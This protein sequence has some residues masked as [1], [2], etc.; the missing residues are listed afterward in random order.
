MARSGKETPPKDGV[1]GAKDSSARSGARRAFGDRPPSGNPGT[2]P[3]E[4]SGFDQGRKPARVR[5]LCF[6]E[7]KHGCLPAYM[8]V[9]LVR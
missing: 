5:I 3:S 4:D 1:L 8:P 6:L 7:K 2:L 9:L